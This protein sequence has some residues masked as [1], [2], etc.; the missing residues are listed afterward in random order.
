MAIAPNVTF[1]NGNAFTHTQANAFPFGVVAFG[2]TTT[3]TGSLTSETVSVS[4]VTFTAI[5]SR[6][7]RLTYF[8]PYMT[9]VSGTVSWGVL[10]LRQGTTTGGTQLNQC[11]VRL[12]SNDGGG[13][14]SHICTFSAGSVNIVAT[15]APSGSGTPT[16]SLARASTYPAWLCVEDIGRA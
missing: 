16:M 5:A 10:R 12:N 7:Y 3:S 8:E 2:S 1:S 15:A 14:V 4:A 13:L 11:Q 6:Y 9:F